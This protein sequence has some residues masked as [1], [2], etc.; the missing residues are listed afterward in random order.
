MID[1]ELLRKGLT[2]LKETVA[3]WE[4]LLSERGPQIDEYE[5][6][7]LLLK[8]IYTRNGLTRRELEPLLHAHD[9]KMQGWVGQQVK[10]GYL[11]KVSAG[12]GKFKYVATPDAIAELGLD[13][14][15]EVETLM[16]ASAEVFSEGWK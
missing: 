8:E 10:R 4:G 11:R 3:E 1:A 6:R 13:E 15:E 14:P 9:T 16:R 7:H 12:V 5:R 2:R